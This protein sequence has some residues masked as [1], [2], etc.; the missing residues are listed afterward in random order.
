MV[1]GSCRATLLR[2]FPPDMIGQGQQQQLGDVYVP[3]VVYA[4]PMIY[5]TQPPPQQQQQVQG[6]YVQ[7]PA[8][9]YPVQQQQI[10]QQQ[11]QQPAVYGQPMHGYGQQ[12]VTYGQ[13]APYVQP[14]AYNPYGQQSIQ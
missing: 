1:M 4:Q 3:P 6:G 2:T 11:Q 8:Q 9:G 5:P 7:F 13:P 10:Q 12:P 14:P